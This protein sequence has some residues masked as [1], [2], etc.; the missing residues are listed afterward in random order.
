M[1]ACSAVSELDSIISVPSIAAVSS[2]TKAE[3][4]ALYSAKEL[5]LNVKFNK[6]ETKPIRSIKIML[7]GLWLKILDFFLSM[8]FLF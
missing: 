5:W 8:I 2:L 3:S 4:V 1:I 7:S 6:T